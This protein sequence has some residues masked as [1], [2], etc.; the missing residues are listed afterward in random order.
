MS[1]HL[2]PE[3]RVPIDPENPSIERHEDLCIRC[4]KCR[5]VCRDEISV[6]TY[7][8]LAK[9]GDVPICI[10]CGQCANVCPVDSITEKSEV[11]ALKAAI[12]DPEKIVIVSTSPSVRVALGEGF[13]NAPGTF[14][15][16]KMVA[17]LRK[18]GVDIVLDTD[19]AADMTIVE[20]ASELLSRVTK[21]SAPLPQFTSCCPA[22]VK[23][24][25]TYYPDLLPHISSAKSPIGMQGP[26]IKTWYAKKQGIDPKKIVNVCL[27][28]CTAKKFEIRRAE[29]NDSASYW[30]DPDLRDMDLCITTREL[31]GWAKEAGIDYANLPESD[32]DSLMSEKSGGGVI[33]GATGGV[34]EA[35]LRAAYEYLN[36]R[37]APKEL[38]QLSEVRGYEGIRTATVKLTDALSVRVAV[39]FGTANV[40]RFLEEQKLDDFDFIEV[41][42]CPGGCIGG[43]GQPKHLETPDEA[44]KE[45]IEGLY[46]KDA[47]MDE[48]V[49]TRNQELNDVYASFYGKPLSDLAEKLLHTSYHPREQDLGESAENYRKL[50]K[51]Q[52][53][54]SDYVE[55][56]KAGEKTRKWKC[57]IC[58]YI[59]E[60]ATPPTE[61]PVCHQGADA[62]DRMKTWKCKLCGYTCEGV[63][64][65]DEC[66]VCHQG[67]DAFEEVKTWKCKICGYICESVTPPD[68]CP[69][70]HQGADAFEEVKT[71]KCKICGYICEGVTP[72][73]ECPVCHQG[74]D[75]FEEI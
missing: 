50:K 47:A 31:I 51:N 10:H 68:E 43:G 11:E 36:D 34:M 44:R 16:G 55:V 49:S 40:R 38:L 21:K 39:I 15:E 56:T 26:T 27:T 69:V 18:L 17:L 37:P 14:S 63:T 67:A 1:M 7:Y 70:C 54:E 19:F 58:G 9:T 52:N 5:D 8:D 45:R 25:E 22:W 41:M 20:E 74:A 35:A 62:F 3:I 53:P 60:G 46:A 13:G 30:N 42:T 66:P 4:G 71:W 32:F 72:P 33:F 73:Q 29:M 12:A 6:L 28:P 59:Y 2:S 75:A 64:P 23:F 61:C 48:K 24:A 65:P 57:R